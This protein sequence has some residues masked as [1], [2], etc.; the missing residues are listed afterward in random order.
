MILNLNCVVLFILSVLLLAP[1]VSCSRE[2]ENRT[3]PEQYGVVKKQMTEAEMLQKG[4][5]I[6]KEHDLSINK[7]RIIGKAPEASSKEIPLTQNHLK[8]LGYDISIPSKKRDLLSIFDADINATGLG[9]TP[10]LIIGNPRPIGRPEKDPNV[11]ISVGIPQVTQDA[12]GIDLPDEISS[13]EFINPNDT[14]AEYTYTYTYTYKEGYRT[15]WQNKVNGSLKIGA[16]AE[17]SIPLIAGGEVTSEIMI[18]GEHTKGE[19]NTTE[20]TVS[21][22]YKTIIAPH[23]KKTITILRKSKESSIKYF[24]PIQLKGYMYMEYAF[25]PT[26]YAFE[27]IEKYTKFTSKSTGTAGIAKSINHTKCTIMESKAEKL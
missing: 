18:G 26:I 9:F 10:D 2:E 12:D 25:F 22:T 5:K 17:I 7:I 8:Q 14:P 3:S 27:D 13:K 4:W 6:V 16:S 15:T 24:V 1:L 20:R 11:F 19:D 21:D 23:S